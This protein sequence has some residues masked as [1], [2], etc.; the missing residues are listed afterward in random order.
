MIDALGGLYSGQ[1]LLTCSH[2]GASLIPQILTSLLEGVGRSDQA[3]EGALKVLRQIAPVLRVDLQTLQ[4]GR[5]ILGDVTSL[6]LSQ[7]PTCPV[8]QF[9]IICQIEW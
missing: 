2:A 5:Q 3:L 1:K 8:S 9:E 6:I 4:D 7:E